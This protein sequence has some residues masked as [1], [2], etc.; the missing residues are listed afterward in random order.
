MK[1]SV[2]CP[3]L[4]A[5]ALLAQDSRRDD[6]VYHMNAA[7]AESQLLPSPPS[8]F[9][10]QDTVAMTPA[11]RRALRASVAAEHPDQNRAMLR[12]VQTVAAIYGKPV[13]TWDFAYSLT[14]VLAGRQ[15]PAET[16]TRIN[17][18]ILEAL[19]SALVSY[20]TGFPLR[21]STRFRTALEQ[22]SDTLKA[23]GV[24][25]ANASITIAALLQTGAS[26]ATPGPALLRP[27]PPAHP[28]TQS[29][30]FYEHLDQ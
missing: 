26:M 20:E 24:S 27:V 4:L 28:V 15:L 17:A 7:L 22:V 3:L 11:D 12:Y 16:L 19:D 8:G 29:D 1:W 13:I 6:A 30:S 2:F 9:V 18:A 25:D 14:N 5:G 10:L 23:S 21:R